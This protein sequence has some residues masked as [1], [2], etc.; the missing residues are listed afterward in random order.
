MEII[1]KEQKPTE[2]TPKDNP[3]GGGAG[4]FV[5]GLLLGGVATYVIIK[6]AVTEMVKGAV[7]NLTKNIIGTKAATVKVVTWDRTKGIAVPNAPVTVTLDGK[8]IVESKTDGQGNATLSI[9]PDLLPGKFVISAIDPSDTRTPRGK[10]TNEIRI[11]KQ[12]EQTVRFEFALDTTPPSTI[13]KLPDG[14]I[15]VK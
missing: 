1:K 4:I 2:P 13:T 9:S 15:V 7:T 6:Y 14:R 8:T 3:E 10:L 11:E 5:L 12:S